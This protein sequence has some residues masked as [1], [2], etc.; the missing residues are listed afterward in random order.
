MA[1][2]GAHQIKIRGAVVGSHNRTGSRRAHPSSKIGRSRQKGSSNSR[3]G[4][5]HNNNQGASSSNRK[6]ARNSRPE[7]HNSR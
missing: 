4:A 7:G 2:R 5:N 3:S 6:R 1:N